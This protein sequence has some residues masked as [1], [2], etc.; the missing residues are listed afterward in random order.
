MESCRRKVT[1]YTKGHKGGGG[2]LILLLVLWTLHRPLSDSMQLDVAD[3]M[4][5]GEPASAPADDQ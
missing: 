3:V 4:V 5:V 2:T 1:F